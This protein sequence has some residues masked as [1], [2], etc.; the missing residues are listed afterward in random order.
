MLLLFFKELSRNYR[1]DIELELRSEKDMVCQT[2][3]HFRHQIKESQE[4][5]RIHNNIE[6]LQNQILVREREISELERTTQVD[7]HLIQ[8]LLDHLS[9]NEEDNL[10]LLQYTAADATE[11]KVGVFVTENKLEILRFEI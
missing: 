7:G 9:S 1:K 8:E 11:M 6:H 5:S 3:S 2:Q 4:L 10:L